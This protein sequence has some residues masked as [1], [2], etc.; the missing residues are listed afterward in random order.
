M[1]RDRVADD[2]LYF[3]DRCIIC[4]RCVRFMREVAE[5]EALIVAQRG[6]KAYIDTF[7]GRDLDNP[8]QGNIVDVCPVGALV[9]EDFLF[10]ARCWDLDQAAAICPGCSTGC[11]VTI[12]T[13]ENQIVRLKPRHNAEVNSYWMCDHGRKHLVMSN[14]GVRAEV[15][16]IRRTARLVAADWSE[17]LAGWRSTRGVTGAMAASFRPAPSNE[18]LFYLAA[19]RSARDRGRQ[20]PSPDRRGGDASPGFPKLALRADRA[21]NVTGAELFGFARTDER[22]T[23]PGPEPG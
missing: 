9:H 3:A 20:L 11:N 4:T 18:S 5:D 19:A 6:H 15:P 7:P 23:P 21:P 10:K 14:R 2:I 16:L 13:K 12:D 17:A 1:G 22:G 8:F